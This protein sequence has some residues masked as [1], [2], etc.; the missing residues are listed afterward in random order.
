MLTTALFASVFV[1]VIGALIL[2][3][4]S[5]RSVNRTVFSCSMHLGLWLLFLHFAMT[6]KPG[7]FWLR[8]ASA[9]GAAVPVHFWLVKESIASGGAGWLKAAVSR[10][11]GWFL[12]SLFLSALPFTDY[13]VP[14]HSTAATRLVGWG[15]YAYIWINLGLYVALLIDT[16]R[17][18]KQLSGG[19]RLELQV[20]L[21][22]G[23]LMVII[24]FALMAL[25]ALT[26]NRYYIILQ[27]I[28]VLT[29]YTGAV[30]AITTNRIF[31]AR[32]LLLVS[33]EKL[34]L[35]V[36]TAT[37]AYLVDLVLEEFLP[38]PFGLFVTTALALWLAVVLNRWLDRQFQFY[39]QA[40][41]ARQAAFSAAQRERK[42]SELEASLSGILQGWGQSDHVV[43]I[44]GPKTEL[45][46]GGVTLKGDD[47]VVVAMQHLG[48]ATPERL[49]R[50]RV[51]R[52]REAVANFLAEHR[53]GVLA[54][55]DGATLAVLVGV[56]VSA[57][58][59]PFTFPQVAQLIE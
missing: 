45:K 16:F 19:R 53:L 56:G 4:N 49:I 50:E 33:V 5:K 38:A 31:D 43:I 20:W 30:V 8:C 17:A 58:R 14:S 7:L 12:I 9:V 10:L 41:D 1:A 24:V 18:T 36:A 54:L 51:T 6:I 29:F 46:G 44:S 28:A 22:G 59:L 13:F 57:S 32:Q 27:P 55:S 47:L 37:A 42:V 39:P 34:I 2:W 40:T 15:Y 21:V 35:V 11:T 23:C 3:S 48:W 52:E 25:N 26:H